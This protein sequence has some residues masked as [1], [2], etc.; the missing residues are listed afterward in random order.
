VVVGEFLV[1][2]AEKVQDRGM[3]IVR[4]DDILAGPEAKLIGGAVAR[5]AFHS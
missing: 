4:S 3:K 2:E 1:I 5:T